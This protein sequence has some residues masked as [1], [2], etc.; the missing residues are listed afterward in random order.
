[1]SFSTILKGN[2]NNSGVNRTERLIVIIAQGGR[3]PGAWRSLE[4]TPA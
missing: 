2:I 4:P 3:P 1:L